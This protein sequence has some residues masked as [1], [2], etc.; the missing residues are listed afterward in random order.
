MT[1]LIL[2]DCHD[3]G[4]HLGAYGRSTVP[5]P[6]LDALAVDGVRFDNSFCT[7]PQCSP[8]RAGLYTGRYPHATGMFGLAHEPFGW[9][10][11]DNEVHL[12]RYLRDAGYT[13][14]QV[15]VQHVTDHAPAAVRELGFQ[16]VRP[17]HH[18]GDVAHLAIDWL[19]SSPQRPFFLNIGFTEPHRDE[20]GLFRQAPPDT[21]QGVEVP[22]YLPQTAEAHAEFAELQGVIGLMDRAVGQIWA[23]LQELD[24]LDDTWLIFTTDHG[25]AMPRAKSTMYDP[26]IETALLMYSQPFGLTGGRAFDRLIS[27]VDLVP[28]ILE[29]LG[30]AVPARI[31]GHSFA[32]LL[33]GTAYEPREYVYAEK[34]FHTDYEPQRAIRSASHKLIW[35][36]EVDIINV[37]GDIMHSPIYPQMINQLTIERPPFEL[38]DLVTDPL[39]QH[40]RINDA[41]YR[42]IA[43]ELR[44][45]LLAWMRRTNDPLLNGPLASPYYRRALRLLTGDGE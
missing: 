31:Q 29:M 36:A 23:A 6:H 11:H 45:H 12:A 4:R 22:A 1:N 43:T 13:T 21:S 27:N 8:S 42:P 20:N 15:G 39:E 5:S 2:I 26:G 35:N 34:T 7:A 14:I 3:L 44:Q 17:A 30:L 24:L 40:N 37:A 25:L 9:R 18:A 19:R 10:L 41:D 38:Y 16:Q 32:G 28:T 33:R